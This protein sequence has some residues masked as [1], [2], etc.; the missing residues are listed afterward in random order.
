MPGVSEPGQTKRTEDES[1]TTKFKNL[2][3]KSSPKS[4]AQ[5]LPED[6]G[7]D[8]GDVP[9]AGQTP[10]SPTTS[11]SGP[12]TASNV[13]S[14]TST[15]VEDKILDQ[16]ARGQQ[17]PTAEANRVGATNLNANAETEW[18]G[19]VKGEKL[20]AVMVD[21][22]SVD[23]SKVVLGGGKKGEGSWVIV[24]VSEARAARSRGLR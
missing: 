4:A 19:V 24:P 9:A 2:F 10:A 23:K 15:A 22:R 8:V 16:N 21:L 3:K 14:T 5:Q 13:Y 11:V 18:P 20:G 1:L 17:M 6:Q 12:D 7:T